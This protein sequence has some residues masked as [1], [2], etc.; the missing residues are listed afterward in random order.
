MRGGPRHAAWR[1][2]RSGRSTPLR[3]VDRV[4]AAYEL[5]DRDRGLLRRL[6]GTE[7]R[8]R[9]TLRAIVQHFAKGKPSPDVAAHLRLGVAQLCFLDRVPPHAAV[10][11][12]VGATADTV[13]LARGRYVN[14]V[15]RTVQRAP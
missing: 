7:V 4:A 1:I 5:D 12:T 8:R 15:L 2:L 10:S 14:G 9:A 13:S 6:V 11:E 3:E